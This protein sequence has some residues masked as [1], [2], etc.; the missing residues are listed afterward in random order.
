MVV[1]SFRHVWSL[2][3]FSLSKIT[4]VTSCYSN[5]KSNAADGSSFCHDL[6]SPKNLVFDKN[7]DNDIPQYTSHVPRLQLL[8]IVY[9]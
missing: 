7:Y 1:I 3:S 9:P 6:E 8:I 2:Q 5:A 4:T